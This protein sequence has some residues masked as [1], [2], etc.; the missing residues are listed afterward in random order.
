[1]KPAALMSAAAACATVALW[2][3]PAAAQAGDPWQFQ[4]SLYLYLP[5]VDSHTDIGA[6]P[7]SST[8]LAFDLRDHLKSFFMGTLEARQGRWGAFTDLVYANVGGSRSGTRDATVGGTPLPANAS[9]DLHYDLRGVAWTLAG[10]WRALPDPAAPLD[11]FAGTRLLDLDQKIDWQFGGNVGSIALPVRTGSEA[12]SL[13]NWDAIV[14][15]K[16]R[17]GLGA[18]R[19]W[20]VPYYLDL[21]AGQSK[22]TWQAMLGLGY[23]F[24]WGDVVGAWRHVDYRMKS[25]SE[26]QRLSFDGPSI[27][28]VWRW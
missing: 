4:G 5:T 8:P 7:G 13:H 28:A 3:A 6:P 19:R 10:S 21:G 25:D 2:P 15:L 18:A 17:I 23:T 16:G 11:L 9:A 27:A 26:L 1:M 14:G 24:G 12:T 22:S 20:F